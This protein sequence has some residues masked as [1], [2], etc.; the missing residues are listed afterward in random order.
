MAA[1]K[2][3]SLAIS[4]DAEAILKSDPEYE[5]LAR[6]TVEEYARRLKR[7]DELTKNS[8]MTEDMAIEL[9]RRARKGI[10]EKIMKDHA[11][12]EA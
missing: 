12:R 5:K 2:V 4:K 7:L 6:A 3:G 8:T 1:T 10:Y 11:R 9:G